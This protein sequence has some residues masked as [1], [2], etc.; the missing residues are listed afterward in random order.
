MFAHDVIG[1]EVRDRSGA[2]IG[3][4]HAVQANPAHDL[5]ELDDGAL[6]PAVFVVEQAPGVLV[7]DLPEGLLDL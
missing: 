2:R 6:I 1:A 3:R 4:V 7:V 5:L